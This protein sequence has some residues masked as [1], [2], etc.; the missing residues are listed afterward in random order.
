VSPFTEI[1]VKVYRAASGMVRMESCSIDGNLLPGLLDPS[2]PSFSASFPSQGTDFGDYPAIA[3]LPGG[4][5][6][7]V[8]IVWHD[9]S[10]QILYTI[11]EFQKDSVSGIWDFNNKY[12][13][14][15]NQFGPGSTRPSVA[16]VTSQ[17]LI[18]PKI[19]IAWEDA[20]FSSIRAR[21]FNHD[22][23]PASDEFILHQHSPGG[24]PSISSFPGRNAFYAA[25]TCDEGGVSPW[26]Q[27]TLRVVK[28]QPWLVV[29]KP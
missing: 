15:A 11:R 5:V 3:L 25:W 22:G 27:S 16:V 7:R 6:S 19:I 8:V 2:F 26:D 10:S 23:V 14:T 24:A 1:L 18:T 13:G 4:V 29:E 20:G 9:T 21:V 12:Y 28:G 17:D